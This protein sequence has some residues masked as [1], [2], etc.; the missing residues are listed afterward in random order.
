MF[1]DAAGVECY[2]FS[3]EQNGRL[4]SSPAF[5]LINKSCC[6]VLCMCAFVGVCVAATGIRSKLRDG[7]LLV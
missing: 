2:F 5:F 3:S 1:G 6:A 4:L 7:G